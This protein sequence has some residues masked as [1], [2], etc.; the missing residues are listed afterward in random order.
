M[1]FCR[2]RFRNEKVGGDTMILVRS[3]LQLAVLDASPELQRHQIA[4]V[5][6]DS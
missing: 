2:R 3:V 4:R 5:L 1:S 6:L